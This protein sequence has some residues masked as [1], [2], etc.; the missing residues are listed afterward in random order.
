M[1]SVHRRL[2]THRA[3]GEGSWASGPFAEGFGG[4][5]DEWFGEAITDDARAEAD[6][7]FA[8][9]MGE[10]LPGRRSV[11]GG[12]ESM[13]AE[14]DLTAEV[15]RELHDAINTR[16]T[17]AQLADERTVVVGFL[18]ARRV[19]NIVR[20]FL[21][22]HVA[23]FTRALPTRNAV[24]LPCH[25]FEAG[26]GTSGPNAPIG[27]WFSVQVL[28][29]GGT[30]PIYE[31]LRRR[32]ITLLPGDRGNGSNPSGVYN[33]AFLT[34]SNEVN[35][36]AMI[37]AQLDLQYGAPANASVTPWVVDP[38]APW[39]PVGVALARRDITARQFGVEIGRSG[40]ASG[41]GTDY[42][43]AM[44]NAY[45]HVSTALNWFLGGALPSAAKEWA[46]SALAQMA[47]KG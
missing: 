41:S 44:A 47:P 14:I 26:F 40:Y 24:F 36:P 13:F 22:A 42:G 5:G 12:G 32:G 9:L 21:H 8:D 16:F 2:A 7:F 31:A 38:V 3:S 1:A 4:E 33:P 11:A 39:K 18:T 10:P 27:N 34:G 15:P 25:T 20:V 23:L 6:R 45:G 35:I 29:T 28:P 46:T 19:F 17:P 43:T 30:A 37:N